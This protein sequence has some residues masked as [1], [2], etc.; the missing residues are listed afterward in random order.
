MTFDW[1]RAQC[2]ALAVCSSWTLSTSRVGE[3]N[4]I[5][6]RADIVSREPSS[7]SAP[8]ARGRILQPTGVAGP[9]RLPEEEVSRN[10]VKVQ[11]LAARS[12]WTDGSTRLWQMRRVQPGTGEAQSALRF[13]QALPNS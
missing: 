2:S 4:S 11:R 1:R 5:S 10:G 3:V 8:P 13:D 6:D 9:Y 12:R 7:V